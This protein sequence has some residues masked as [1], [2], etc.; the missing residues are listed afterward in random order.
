[1][2]V[3]LMVAKK[4]TTTAF[5]THSTTTSITTS[6]TTSSSS[7]RVH[8]VVPS[9]DRLPIITMTGAGLQSTIESYDHSNL[10]V[11]FVCQAVHRCVES[12]SSATAV[13][14][15][16]MTSNIIRSTVL[17]SNLP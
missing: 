15:S 4:G 13:T 5:N 17:S 12:E 8:P 11:T 9:M 3:S 14:L 1:M 6:T 7:G 10:N 16:I 2:Q